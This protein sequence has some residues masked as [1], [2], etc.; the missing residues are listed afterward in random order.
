[1]SLVI[2]R[3]ASRE[4]LNDYGSYEWV[5]NNA[6]ERAMNEYTTEAFFSRYLKNL[7]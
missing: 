5:I 1:M 6:Y 7:I 4:V 2:L 3:V